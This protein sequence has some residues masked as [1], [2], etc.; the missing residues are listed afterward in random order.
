MISFLKKNSNTLVRM[1]VFQLAMI[2]FSLAVLT[3]TIKSVKL[4]IAACCLAIALYCY[5][6]YNETWEIGAKD[7]IKI[8]RGRLTYSRFKGLYLS[9]GANLLNLFLAL[10]VIVF[11]AIL[12][13]VNS[14]G[15][16]MFFFSAV[17]PE[18][19]SALY[20]L[21][22]IPKTIAQFLQIM[23]SRIF[24]VAMPGNPFVYLIA[25]ILPFLFCTL[26]YIAGKNNFTV[27][28]QKKKPDTQA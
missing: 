16:K 25:L 4:N 1:N 17:V 3:A 13:L 28:P 24:T 11:K 5:L 20:N 15:A 21:Y 6:L 12:V 9:I 2:V 19:P 8:E 23:Y 22:A 26:G 10:L 7:A 18:T 27:F 14:G